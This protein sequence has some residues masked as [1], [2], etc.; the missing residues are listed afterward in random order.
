MS[1]S[2]ETNDRPGAGASDWPTALHSGRLR[3]I[4]RELSYFLLF[5]LLS[6]VMTWPLAPNLNTAVSDPGDPYLN[7][8]ILHWD[9]W[10]TFHQPLDL[11]HANI[12]HPARYALAFSENMYG[13]AILLFPLYAAGVEVI[14][15]YNVAML[16]GFA[17]CGY[18]AFVLCRMI[19]GSAL[20]AIAGGIFFAFVPFRFDHLAHIQIVWA[21]W[22]PIL[23][24]AL[25][26]FHEKATWKRAMLLGAA[27]LMNGLTN[28]HWLMFGSLTIVL[29]FIFLSSASRRWR[30]VQYQRR[31]WLSLSVAGLLLLP[32]LIPYAIASDLYS[33]K[34]HVT[35][36]TAGSA[37]PIDWLI[38]SERNLLYGKLA[39]TKAASS[40]RRLFP[41]LITLALTLVALLKS[42]KE[43][44]R[45]RSEAE[46]A[47]SNR[48]LR[49][50][51]RVLMFLALLVFVC[52]VS[53]IHWKI[54]GIV[55]R[56]S[57]SYLA[58]TLFVVALLIR[59]WIRYPMAFGGER[60]RSLRSLI[61]QSRFPLRVWVAILWVFVGLAG[62]LGMRFFFHRFLFR[63]F[64]FQSIRTPA[65]WAIVAYVGLACLA[66]VGALVLVRRPGWR[67]SIVGVSLSVLLLFELRAAPIPWY[68]YDPAP[69][70]LYL[71]LKELPLTGAVVELPFGA[72]R[73]AHYVLQSTRH[74]QRL[75]NGVSGFFPEHH[76]ALTA[77]WRSE[78][79]DP[80]LLS[81]LE[82]I[83]TSILIVHGDFVDERRATVTQWLHKALR[84]G[85][86]IYLGRFEHEIHGSYAFAL[87]RVEPN[88]WKWRQSEVPDPAGRTPTQNLLLYL[89]DPS[90]R[91][92]AQGVIGELN[93]PRQDAEIRGVLDVSGWALSREGIREVIVR[94]SNGAFEYRA[95]LVP[96]TQINAL[97]P[98][99]SRAHPHSG[100]RLRINERPKRMP[101][102]TDMQIE[103]VDGGGRRKVLDQRWIY[104]TKVKAFPRVP[105]N[106]W[107]MEEVSGLLTRLGRP[108]QDLK[109]IADGRLQLS[110]IVIDEFAQRSFPTNDAYVRALYT[111]LLDREP[112]FDGL[113]DY[114]RKLAGGST[115]R[116]ITE[117][118]MQGGEFRRKYL[119]KAYRNSIQ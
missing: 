12:F 39:I 106:A 42:R 55:I 114:L 80:E 99:Y 9:Y 96:Q 26:Y 46:S 73:E 72:F 69:P 22:L 35:E 8:W 108:E 10:A 11:Y 37:T 30:D 58:T 53:T 103:I 4:L 79:I 34:R 3:I 84:S 60:G 74:V 38:A 5:L 25:L 50:L 85:Q 52:T 18:G 92:Y 115:R 51:D 20:A 100:F 86:L 118:V 40:E 19:T 57:S 93:R 56:S 102:H 76:Q 43:D 21:G 90:S 48:N 98:W 33:M 117:S 32:F 31:F 78:P 63:I 91:S 66:A 17:F 112:E 110:N 65:R 83:R 97:Y 81:S 116:S 61:A 95:A 47:P 14:T 94:F 41:G 89:T 82:K 24:A 2:R 27:F 44:F 15:A 45:H 113:Q 88:A 49:V 36:N 111:I 107:K 28:I 54:G 70:P 16:L 64:L 62:S 59:L 101:S 71:W 1:S 119:S 29:S 68:L 75:V 13:L 105:P 23:L 87:P 6:V 67:R 7:A 109:A 104:W 77:M